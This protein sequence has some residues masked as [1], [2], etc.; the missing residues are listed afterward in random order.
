M[1]RFRRLPLKRK[2][3]SRKS[4]HY[5]WQVK[6]LSALLALISLFLY[7]ALISGPAR[8][9]TPASDSVT[10]RLTLTVLPAIQIE[11]LDAGP[12]ETSTEAVS[13]AFGIHLWANT[14]WSLSEPKMAGGLAEEGSCSASRTT[15]ARNSSDAPQEISV[16]C[17]QPLS[18]ADQPGFQEI[19]LEQVISLPISE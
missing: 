18:W 16:V 3:G 8:A 2:T 5:F 10:S 11:V 12:Q 9:I 17:L 6:P 14:K 7:L 13:K 15:G 19:T 4:W 1:R